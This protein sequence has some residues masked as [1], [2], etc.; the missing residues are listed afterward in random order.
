MRKLIRKGNFGARS[1]LILFIVLVL[2]LGTAWIPKAEAA[3]S[4]VSAGTAATSGSG[5]VSPGIPAGI[6]NNDILV[7]VIH[8]HD[9]TNSSMPAGW[10]E[11]VAGNGNANNR[12]EIW[13]KRTT[14]TE[15]SPTVTHAGGTIIAKIYAFRG[16]V[17]SGDPFN[18]AGIIQSNAGSPISTAAITTTVADTMILHAFGCE[19]NN[20]WDSFTGT[21]STLADAV[22]VNNQS[23]PADDNSMA[24]TYGIMASAGSTGTAGASQVGFGSDPGVSVQLALRP[25]VAP[26]TAPVSPPAGG[27]GS[28]GVGP[29][30]IR[31]EGS[32]YPGSEVEV[33]RKILDSPYALV[34]PEI[35]YIRNDG[36]FELQFSTILQGINTFSLA[37]RAIDRE[38]N[39]SNIVYPRT[40]IELDGSTLGLTDILM[41]PTFEFERQ[42]ITKGKDLEL[43]GFAVPHQNIR[44]VVDDT[45]NYETQADSEGRYA[46]AIDTSELSLGEHQIKSVYKPGLTAS[47]E[48]S[49]SRIFRV[50]SLEYTIIDLNE[51]EMISIQD[52]SIFLSRTQSQEENLKGTVDLNQNGIVDIF[53]FSIFLN[54]FSKSR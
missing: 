28:P 36:S 1:F 11:K 17:E 34:T 5:N 9:N 13:W 30:I 31:L 24:L 35:Y 46:I 26:E 6:Q 7:A 50:S 39:K 51:D 23:F 44:F 22:V 18:V 4:Y 20:D 14:G 48:Y 49:P 33:M 41:P 37:F 52:W 2:G 40:L 27:A 3:V 29:T 21:A 45:R 19:D 25:Y 43:S 47:E 32:S 10:A 15:S 54:L 8:S 12:M 16:A 42:R 38:G 53:D